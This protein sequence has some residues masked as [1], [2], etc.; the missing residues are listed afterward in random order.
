MQAFLEGGGTTLSWCW[1]LTLTNGT[2]LYFNDSD[3]TITFGGHDYLPTPGFKRTAIE[4]SEGLDANDIELVGLIDASN[5]TRADIISGVYSMAK[6]LLFIVN[7]A[8]TSM[9]SISELS[10]ING[11]LSRDR[12]RW[13]FQINGITKQLSQK[14]GEVTSPGCRATFGDRNQ[15]W[16]GFDHQQQPDIHGNAGAWRRLLP[17]WRRDMDRRREQRPQDGSPRLG[18]DDGDAADVHGL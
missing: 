11:S 15:Y 12:S 1:K 17:I 14:F 9:G 18:R 6:V 10:G 8:D 3:G 5:I 4:F 16:N 2:V 7:R 13:T